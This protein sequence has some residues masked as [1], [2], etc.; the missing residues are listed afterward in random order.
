MSSI[1][2]STDAARMTQPGVK[3][4]LYEYDRLNQSYERSGELSEPL[5]EQW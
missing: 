2:D 4:V 5:Q 1:D 3:H